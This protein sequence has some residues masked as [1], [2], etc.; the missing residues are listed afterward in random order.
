MRDAVQGVD[1][2]ASYI[3]LGERELREEQVM[4][5]KCI[6]GWV[7][8]SAGGIAIPGATDTEAMFISLTARKVH[9]W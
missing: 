1:I 9:E 3:L 8:I 4:S 6:I 7:S 2:D 5:L